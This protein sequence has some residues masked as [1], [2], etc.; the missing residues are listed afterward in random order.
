MLKADF[1]RKVMHLNWLV[2]AIL[3]KKMNEKWCVYIDFV[4]LIEVCPKDSYP[5][6]WIDQMVDAT[7]GHE[8][9]SFMDAFSNYNRSR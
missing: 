9:F 4:N 3:N 6:S 1:I 8:F 2:N 7:S 5:L